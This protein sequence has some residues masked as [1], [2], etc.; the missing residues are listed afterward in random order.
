MHKRV[1]NMPVCITL[2]DGRKA[3]VSDLVLATWNIDRNFWPWDFPR[4][5]TRFDVLIVEKKVFKKFGNL[6]YN[7]SFVEDSCS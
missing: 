6:N 1:Y 4:D 5:L 3:H 2:L 7:L